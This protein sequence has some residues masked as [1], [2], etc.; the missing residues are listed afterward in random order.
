MPETAIDD[1]IQA[2]IAR[3]AV[4]AMSLSGGKDSTAA[5]YA[6][7]QILDAGGHSRSRRI[8]VHADLGRAEWRETPATVEAI[9]A[10]LGLPLHVVRQTRH[11]PV[12]RWHDRFER[13]LARYAAFETLCLI[14]P[15][16]SAKLRFCTLEAKA[17]VITRFLRSEIDG[18]EV[19]SVIGIRRAESPARRLAPIAATDPRLTDRART[20]GLIWHPLV[21]W[22]ADEVF[23]LHDAA[24]LPLH[25]AYTTYGSSRF[26]CAACVLASK[27]DLEASASC[28][29]NAKLFG[30]LVDLE[31]RST[32]SFQPGRWLADLSDHIIGERR[33][34]AIATAK[35]RAA[36]RRQLEAELPSG[37]RYVKG[38]HCACQRRPRPMTSPTSEASSPTTTA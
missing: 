17:S 23:A 6:A 32:F 18:Q 20:S 38:G 27:H 5:A 9:A 14:G 15:W 31:A 36:E 2:A 1:R 8:G 34:A 22:S 30:T 24:G 33:K 3:G 11:D 25:V 35:E 21:D 37:L 12:G 16:S 26:S 29:G 7:S 13:G 4:V 19:V 28:A 10:T